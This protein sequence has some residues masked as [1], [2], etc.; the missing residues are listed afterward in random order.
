MALDDAIG[1]TYAQTRKSD[2]RIFAKL[3]EIL[4]PYQAFVVIDVGAGTGSYTLVLAEHG[5][6]I[7][8]VEPSG[9]MRDQAIVHPAIQWIDA[10]AE[11]LPLPDQ[12][13]D[14]AIIMLAFHHFQNHQQALHEVRRVTGNGLLVLFT[15]DPEA[16]SHFWLTQYFPALIADVQST[17]LPMPTL[18]SE[19]ETITHTTVTVLPFLLPHDLLDAFAAVGWSRPE[20]YLD[21]KVRAGISSFT[22]ISK[23]ELHQGL[24]SLSQDLE[25]GVW[26]QKYG[27][28]RHQE[29]Y[30]IGYRFVYTHS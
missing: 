29:Q 25:A 23:T 27:H 30:D 21:S 22:K 14:A 11:N 8:A 28:L 5:Y 17:F 12:S 15:Y 4:K 3:L 7:L 9:R 10:C 13:A 26:D 19:I 24:V 2:P 16:I 18:I 6:Q 1:K 20:L